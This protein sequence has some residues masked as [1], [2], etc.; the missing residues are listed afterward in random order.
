MDYSKNNLVEWLEMTLMEE[1]M[2]EREAGDGVAL[3]GW[4]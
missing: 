2:V 4:G 3:G 1:C